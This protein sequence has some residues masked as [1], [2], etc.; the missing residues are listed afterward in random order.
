MGLHCCY[1]LTSLWTLS[2]WILSNNSLSIHS[3]A[4]L[5]FR[6]LTPFFI[7][8]IVL[9]IPDSTRAYSLQPRLPLVLTS[10]M[11]ST[12]VSTRSR[13]SIWTRKFSSTCS[14]ILLNCLNLVVLFSCQIPGLL[15][16]F[17]RMGACECDT[18]CS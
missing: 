4:L 18:S 2:Q 5:K 9:Q 8:A 13:M 11:I 3:F 16:S 15:K 6:V 12:L 7:K 17:I 1:I 14:R 10:S